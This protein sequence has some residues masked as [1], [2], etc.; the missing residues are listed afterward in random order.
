VDT[1]GSR[2]SDQSW[3]LSK[4]RNEDWCPDGLYNAPWYSA[5]EPIIIGG[6]PRSGSTLLRL[7]LG[8]HKDLIDGPETHLFL[9]LPIDTMRLESR[10]RMPPGS[11]EGI[12][13]A[14]RT[15]GAFIEEFQKFLLAHSG[16]RRWVEKTS[17]N[18]HSFGW[19]RDRFPSA[20]LLHIIRDPRDVVA[21]LRT[22]PRFKRGRR[23]RVISNWQQPWSECIDRWKRC[24]QDGIRLR[25]ST[26]YLEVIYESLVSDP[27]GT[28]RRVCAHAGLQF[29]PSMLNIETRREKMVGALRP[30]VINNLEAGE[31]ITLDSIGRWRQELP[32]EVLSDIQARLGDLALLTGYSLEGE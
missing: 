7:L 25:S 28:L 8:G 32:T 1:D 12:H 15:R 18:V 13:D 19:I 30:F 26:R 16:C 20:T 22:H 21:S 24:V 27:E 9:P 14:A 23:E 10:F 17:R 2:Q 6:C 4:W 31:P 11:L 5:S 3:E 29:D